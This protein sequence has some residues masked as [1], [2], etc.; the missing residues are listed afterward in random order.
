MAEILNRHGVRTYYISLQTGLSDHDSTQFHYGDRRE[1][2]DLSH[3]FRQ[4]VDSGRKIVSLL[5]G[6]KKDFDISCCLATGDKALLLHKAG[7]KY[8]YWSFGSD[9]DQFS[10][11]PMWPPD[12]PLWKKCI[13]YP[14][15]ALT[16]RRAQRASIRLC[17]SL[18]IVPY[19]Q[20]ALNRISPGKKLFFVSHF[21]NVPD[22][23][24]LSQRKIESSRAICNAIGADMFFF[25]AVRHFWGNHQSSFTDNKGNDVA[26]LAFS[27]YIKKATSN[28]K[29]VLVRKGPDV[30]ASM[31]L[32][33]KLGIS[34][35]IVWLK[36]MAREELDRYYEGAALCLGQFATPVISFAVLEPLVHGTASISYFKNEAPDV[37][38]YEEI[39]PIIDSKDPVQIADA[40][41]RLTSNN[42]YAA[43]TSCKSWLWIKDNCS[44]E[45]F[46]ATF[47]KSF[48]KGME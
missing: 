11:S 5:A 43:E 39:P 44:E 32:A 30:D 38:F 19:Q 22:Y 25:S 20:N 31:A 12:Y 48:E 21:F 33:E 36:E 37:P 3:L 24:L 29:L 13:A 2:W 16:E 1:E 4:T 46:V 41:D 17:D 28:V 35:N 47:L 10:F 26:L 9:L 42:K 8:N 27:G 7:I 34:S 40:M 6:I 18:M 15:F 45:R 23:E 14:R